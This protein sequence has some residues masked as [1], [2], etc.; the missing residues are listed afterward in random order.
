M[1]LIS[2]FLFSK[3]YLRLAPNKVKMITKYKDGRTVEY[4]RT[5][6]GDGNM[7]WKFKDG[8]SGLENEVYYEKVN[9]LVQD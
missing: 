9:R 4:I 6:L 5:Q 1:N 7:I 3:T 2:R 8:G